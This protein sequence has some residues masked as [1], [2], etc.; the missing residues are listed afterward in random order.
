MRENQRAPNG[1]SLFYEPDSV[2]DLVLWGAH[3]ADIA[4]GK[5][6]PTDLQMPAAQA[7]HFQFQGWSHRTAD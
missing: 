4:D 1:R 7:A 3:A 5:D 2:R 6:A